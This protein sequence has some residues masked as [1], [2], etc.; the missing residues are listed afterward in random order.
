MNNAV[1]PSHD[2]T[3]RRSNHNT[4][5]RRYF[6][7][8]GEVCMVAPQDSAEPRSVNEALC[9]LNAKEW[10]DTMKNEMEFMRTNQ[11]WDLGDL[12]AGY[13]AIESK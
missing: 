2:Q 13:K 10:M 8:E 1:S 6:E 5:P 7:I 11:I 3:L 12:P 4:I 9:D